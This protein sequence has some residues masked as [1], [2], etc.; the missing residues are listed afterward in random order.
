MNKCGQVLTASIIE[1]DRSAISITSE[2][3]GGTRYIFTVV[4]EFGR[5]Y[6]AKFKL[7]VGVNSSVSKYFGGI[8]VQGLDISVEPSYLM[9]VSQSSENL[10]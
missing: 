4:V 3:L 9:A 1:G 8:P 5:P 7:S 10:D 6:I 2:Y